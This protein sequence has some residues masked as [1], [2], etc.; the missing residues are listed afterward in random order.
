M[1]QSC[2]LGMIIKDH[3]SLLFQLFDDDLKD[4]KL[5]MLTSRCLTMAVLL[6]FVYLGEEGLKYTNNCRFRQPKDGVN[7]NRSLMLVR[8]FKKNLLDLGDQGNKLYYIMITDGPGF[9][10]DTKEQKEFI[11]HVLVIEKLP[12]SKQL[13]KY[14]MYQSYVRT[15][16]LADHYHMNNMSY[17]Y[18]YANMA[19][20]GN[21]LEDFFTNMIWSDDTTQFWV[22]FIHVNES[23]YTNYNFHGNVEFCYQVANTSTCTEFLKK[24]II[25]KKKSLEKYTTVGSGVSVYGEPPITDVSLLRKHVDLLLSKLD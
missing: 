18:S 4:Y 8:E 6:F 24:K 21:R 11:G 17:N 23:R 10:I 19:E 22:K 13:P 12:Q 25:E 14:M 20:F 7:M 3:I 2:N 15:Y 5:Q 16:Q 9:H 1:K